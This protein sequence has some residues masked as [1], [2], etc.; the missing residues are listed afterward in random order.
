[1]EVS[2]SKTKKQDVA[3][4]FGDYKPTEKDWLMYLHV[5]LPSWYI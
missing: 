3:D 2:V 5:Q 1:M 4:G